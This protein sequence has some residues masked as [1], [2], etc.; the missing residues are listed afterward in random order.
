MNHSWRY[1]LYSSFETIYITYSLVTR[2]KCYTCFR[3][4]VVATVPMN[5]EYE[6]ACVEVM[7]PSRILIMMPRGKI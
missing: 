7:M 1:T 5:H 6:M 4:L 2:A 3:M